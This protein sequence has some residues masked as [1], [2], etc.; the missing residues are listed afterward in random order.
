LIVPLCAFAPLRELFLVSHS[1]CL[2][3]LLARA[4][5][6]SSVL[7]YACGQKFLLKSGHDVCYSRQVAHQH[8]R[9]L[10]LSLFENL[11]SR[12]VSFVPSWLNNPP[13]RNANEYVM[14]N[15][16]NLISCAKLG[17]ENFCATDQLIPR[18]CSKPCR[19]F[20]A[21]TA[22]SREIASKPTGEEFCAP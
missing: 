21:P 3:A 22:K 20:C 7:Y 11:Q 19:E 1:S 15:C 18:R 5:V 2:L 13:R 10:R 12:F 14:L 8:G 9:H 6:K 16:D 17:G 4:P